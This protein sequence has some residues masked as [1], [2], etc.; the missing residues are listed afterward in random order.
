MFNSNSNSNHSNK[1][2]SG[3]V[4]IEAIMACP[5]VLEQS[6]SEKSL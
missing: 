5:S 2:G 1:P 3:G 4:R 6:V